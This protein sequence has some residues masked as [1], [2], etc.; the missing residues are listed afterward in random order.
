MQVVQEAICPERQ[1]GDNA[2]SAVASISD[3]Y[4]SNDLQVVKVSAHSFIAK[5][6][7]VSVLGVA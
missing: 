2:L 4:V 1:L 5:G 7:G 6:C 3:V